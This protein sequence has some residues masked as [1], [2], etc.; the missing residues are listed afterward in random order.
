M[1]SPALASLFDIARA[2]LSQGKLSS[3]RLD[4]LE[5]AAASPA[6]TRQRLLYLHSKSVAI[7]SPLLN[8]TL[9]EP[10]PNSTTQIDPTA[11][12][13]PY[14]TVKQAMLDGWRIIH[15]PD[16]RSPFDDREMDILG[17]EFI[18]EKLI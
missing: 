10:D 12:E 18:L 15:F 5:R 8:A 7:T 6:P 3:A 2:E 17:F 9:Y 14:Q 4:E 11:P 13:L 16:Q 1:T